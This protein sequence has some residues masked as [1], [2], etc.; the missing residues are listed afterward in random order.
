M[1]KNNP[2]GMVDSGVGG[3]TVIKEAQKQLPNEQFI[4]IG[5]TARMPYGQ[6][7]VD[8]VI[9]YTFQMANYLMTEKHIKLLVI[10]CNTATAAALPQ[11]Q[12]QL[13]IPVI[14]VIQ[15]GAEAAALR[16][17]NKKIGLIATAGTVNSKAYENQIAD[18]GQDITLMSQAEPDFVQLVESNHYKTAIAQKVVSEHLATFKETA[19]DT[20]ILGCTHFPLLSSFIQ[21]AVGPEVQLID[22]GRET[23]N[24][25]SSYL[26]RYDLKSEIKYQH[27][28][29]TYYTTS[30]PEMF[31][32]IAT[33]WL[34]RHN[35]LDVRHLNII[36]TGEAQ[37]LEGK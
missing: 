1:N 21:V 6:R 18:Y 30:D 7:P 11:L 19:I 28:N 10:A 34:E 27:D 31:K 17:K 24:L 16:T 37:H 22:A 3:L 5:D 36:G 29:D 2:I 23:V 20:L 4:F 33:Q 26:D 8:E 12:L 35:E 13:S 14:G 25:I 32:L 15:P 9:A